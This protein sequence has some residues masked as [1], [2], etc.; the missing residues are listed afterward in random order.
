MAGGVGEDAAVTGDRFSELIK[1]S[2]VD[3]GTA[4]AAASGGDGNGNAVC[5]TDISHSRID[6]RI[7]VS[8]RGGLGSHGRQVAAARGCAGAGA[9]KDSSGCMCRP[10]LIQLPHGAHTLSDVGLLL[11]GCSEEL[12]D[13]ILDRFAENGAERLVVVCRTV[14][15]GLQGDDISFCCALD[16]CEAELCREV[17][18]QLVEPG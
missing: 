7:H 15:R 18:E 3:G 17:H 16:G 13:T 9:E 1:S 4:A 8:H 2:R 6:D 12:A 11:A 10:S 5:G 14:N